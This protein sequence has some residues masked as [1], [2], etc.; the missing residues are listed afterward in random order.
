[1]GKKGLNKKKRLAKA[2][3]K[4]KRMPPF[5]FLKTNRRVTTNRY[6]REWRTDKLHIT[7]EE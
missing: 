1:M 4:N 7:D 6:R 2:I 3:R 5:I